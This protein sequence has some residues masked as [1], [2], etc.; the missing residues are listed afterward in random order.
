MTVRGPIPETKDVPTLEEFCS[1]F[2]DGHARANRHKPA[3]IAQKETAL[4]VHLIPQLG[5]K[6]LDAITTE[7]VQ[8][9][10]HALKDKAIRTVNNVL[11]VLNTC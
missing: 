8:R 10:K 2:L 9:L 11:T 5:T 7:D 1:R 4:R 6:R 3:G